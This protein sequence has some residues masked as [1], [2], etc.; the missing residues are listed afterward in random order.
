MSH[1]LY[2][3]LNAVAKLHKFGRTA[4]Y[5]LYHPQKV[6]RKKR[7]YVDSSS[8]KLARTNCSEVIKGN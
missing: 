8:S 3:L 4:K 2:I 7:A 1:H 6:I 5:D